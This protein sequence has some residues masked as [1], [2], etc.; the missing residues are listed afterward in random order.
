[1][2][3]SDK[4][5]ELLIGFSPIVRAMGSMVLMFLPLFFAGVIFGESLRRAG[6]AAGPLASNLS[7]SVVGGVLEYGSLL[8]GIK[9]LYVLAAA[10]YVGA[11]IAYRNQRE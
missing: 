5:L 10:I 9:S 11:M 4:L 1:M 2:P 6:E 8:W 7:G 3:L